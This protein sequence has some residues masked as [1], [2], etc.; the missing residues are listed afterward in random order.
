[1]DI[2]GKLF[3][4]MQEERELAEKMLTDKIEDEKRTKGTT[5]N[6]AK[7]IDAFQTD[8]QADDSTEEDVESSDTE[9]HAGMVEVPQTDEIT[10]ATLEAAAEKERLVE[11]TE[12]LQIEDEQTGIL[13]D[14]EDSDST[15]SLSEKTEDTQTG[16][17]TDDV[18]ES[19]V[20][21]SVAAESPTEKID[22]TGRDDQAGEVIETDNQKDEIKSLEETEN[23]KKQSVKV[24]PEKELLLKLKVFKSAMDISTGEI[25]PDIGVKEGQ[26]R[27][28]VLVV[29]Y[30]LD[31]NSFKD[32]ILIMIKKAGV[33]YII[34]P[35]FA[36]RLCKK[37]ADIG[38]HLIKCSH[39]KLIDE[40]NYIE[41]YREEGVIYDV[42]NGQEYKFELMTDYVRRIIVQ[43]VKVSECLLIGDS[44]N[45]QVIVIDKNQIKICVN[46]LKIVTI[47]L[48]KSTPIDDEIKIKVLKINLDQADLEIEA[49]K[50]VTINRE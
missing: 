49:P 47:Y 46:A 12:S 8:K 17:L 20:E 45:I 33:D 11:E 37:T 18:S 14:A 34:A 3:V 38:L 36:E 35:G 2:L 24:E 19:V 22:D 28:H 13:V 44:L 4:K 26:L 48:H 10:E 40:G 32:E 6:E 27:N 39:T 7:L 31:E 23:E 43:K 41:V 15:E 25:I 30:N 42:D 1:M 5:E 29:D 50:D 21:D 16:K 9:I